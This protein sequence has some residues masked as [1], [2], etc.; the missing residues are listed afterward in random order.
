MS[1]E[2]A[3]V[4]PPEPTPW[5]AAA[6]AGWVPT[7]ADV[8]A[9]YAERPEG[10]RARPKVRNSKL[11]AV[12]VPVFEE[13]GQAHVVLIERSRVRGTH[14]GDIA[15]PGGV[16]HARET[17]AHAALR[18]TQEEIGIRPSDVELVAT[19]DEVA[20]L[21][22][23]LIRPYVGLLPGR[24]VLRVDSSEVERVLTVPLADLAR[25]GAHWLATYGPDPANRLHHFHID[26]AVGWGT[27][28]DL[29]ADLLT[30]AV[31]GRTRPEGGS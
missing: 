8:R 22:A 23:F 6:E 30:A 12:L 17:P 9:G 18:E 16:L 26:D 2:A 15:F 13:A 28:G 11:S 31:A 1:S 7:V 14:K 5:S 10:R 29:L 25:P 3:P 24:P 27:T 20:T 19:L 4:A 21:T